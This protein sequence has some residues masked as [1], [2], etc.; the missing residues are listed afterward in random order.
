M[1]TKSWTRACAALAVAFCTLAVAAPGFP[2]DGD[3]IQGRL[4]SAGEGGVVDLDAG[5]YLLK[6]PLTFSS[7]VTVNGPLKGK[8][9]LDA[10]ALPAPLTLKVDR[11]DGVLL[12][13][14]EFRNVILHVSGTTAHDAGRDVTLESCTFIDTKRVDGAPTGFILATYATRLTVRDCTFLRSR[15]HHGEGVCFWRSHACK[16]EKCRFGESGSDFPARLFGHFTN[17]VYVQGW[18]RDEHNSN[19]RCVDITLAGNTIRRSPEAAPEEDHGIYA[20]GA[21]GLS[22]CDNDISGWTTQLSGGA[23]KA[24][25]G[26]D[27]VIRRNRCTGSGILLYNYETPPYDLERV[28]VCDNIVKTASWDE[29]TAAYRAT[30]ISYWRQ[31][32]KGTEKSIRIEDNVVENGVIVI[33]KPLNAADFNADGGGVRRNKA[34]AIVLPE[35]VSRE[36]NNPRLKDWVPPPLPGSATPAAQ[37]LAP[38]EAQ[39]DGMNQGILRVWTHT[40]LRQIVLGSV[41]VYDEDGREL[42]GKGLA[43]L[44]KKGAR[45]SF[46]ETDGKFEEL[47]LRP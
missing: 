45:L 44:Y 33:H 27:Y 20:H 6:R 16:L 2:Q 37:P 4:D 22:I 47:R 5:N 8:A 17:A 9:V 31:D 24:R 42:T 34:D 30:G 18:D 25:D 38:G 21:K 35:D 40:G 3:T 39:V 29:S 43:P 12:R 7:R 11:L 46:K 26:C 15:D 13:R 10:S 41:K 19:L 14:L 23:I 28:Q 1:S 32:P 36:S